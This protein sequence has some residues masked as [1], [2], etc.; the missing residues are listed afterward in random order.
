MSATAT[1]NRD[2]VIAWLA[3]DRTGPIDWPAPRWPDPEAWDDYGKRIEAAI[4]IASS[5]VRSYD[6]I[7]HTVEHVPTRRRL[8]PPSTKARPR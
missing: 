2:A 8:P 1:P 4:A 7:V 5:G 3:G 6:A